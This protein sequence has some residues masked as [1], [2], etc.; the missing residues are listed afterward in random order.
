MKNQLLKKRFGAISL[1]A[2]LFFNIATAN[3][4]Q[5]PFIN[6]LL[7]RN[8]EF[9]GLYVQKKREGKSF[10]AIEPLRQRGEQEFRKGNI[11]GLLEIFGEGMAILENRPWDDKQKFL[12]SLTIETNCLVLEPN[13]ELQVSLA[14]MFNSN[15]E[16]AFP[17]PPTVTFELRA[18]K[19]DAAKNFR[20]MTI[21]S[22]LAIAETSTMASR[23][24]SVPD[25]EYQVVA[26]LLAEGQKVGEVKKTIYAIGAFSNRIDIMKAAIAAIKNSTD[27]KVKAVAEQ[28]TTPEFWLQRLSAYNQSVGEEPPNP[29]EELKRIE[30]AVSALTKGQ[31][32]FAAERG[33]LERAYLASDGKLVPYRIYVPKSYDGKVA[34]PF[35][36][37]L[38]GAL[39]DEK[40]YFSNLY[41]EAVI[42]GEAEKRNWIFAAPNGRGRFGGYRGLGLEDVF[43]VM[44]SVKRDYQTDVSRTYLTGHSMG[45]SGTWEVARTH[46]ELFAAISPVAGGGRKAGDDLT[47]LIESVRPLP[48]LIVH[49][50]KDGIVPP[51][52]S[53]EMFAAT[54]KAG[55]NV[56][57]LENPEADHILI[58]GATFVEVLN[59]FEKNVKNSTG[60]P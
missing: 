3:A 1:L 49:G 5:I 48:I 9:N 32:P 26:T 25:G 28:I 12:T 54:Q 18:A 13:A 56:K 30:T 38:H 41:D 53:R 40:S 20:P 46:P 31:N 51:Q 29:I 57:Y 42:K 19:A 21:G 59:F 8:A 10:P 23:R 52:G 44:E 11:L 36:V 39:G 45:G 7:A 34:R 2:L 17:N 47:K 14:R 27:A 58:V 22:N 50:A 15:F 37:M 33:E 55:L 16:K 4:Q 24:L 6:E 43:K 35:V 60:K